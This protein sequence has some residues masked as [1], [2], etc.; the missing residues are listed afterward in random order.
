VVH[1]SRRQETEY[2]RTQTGYVFCQTSRESGQEMGER[3]MPIQEIINLILSILAFIV[4]LD[5]VY[6]PG[7]QEKEDEPVVYIT[8]DPPIAKYKY[9]KELETQILGVLIDNRLTAKEICTR[10]GRSKY[11]VEFHLIKMFN[12]GL[13]RNHVS[14]YFL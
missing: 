2:D 12:K 11:E 3:E 10:L 5:I 6:S 9:K 14:K 7:K 13:I 4:V 1:A 8:N